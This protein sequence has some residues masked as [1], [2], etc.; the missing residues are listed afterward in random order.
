M[1]V[2]ANGYRYYHNDEYET[3]LHQ[4]YD[5]AKKGLIRHLLSHSIVETTNPILKIILQYYEKTLIF[6]MKY[7][8]ILK[9]F[10]NYNW[11]NR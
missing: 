4:P 8:D 2:H 6:L 5:Y 7:V 3:K 10:K 1:E 11:Q 9:N